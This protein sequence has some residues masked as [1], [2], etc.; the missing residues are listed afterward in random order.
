MSP[1]ITTGSPAALASPMLAMSPS[2]RLTSA[3]LPAPSQ[4]TTSNRDLR[5]ESAESTTGRSVRFIDWYERASAEAA[6]RPMTTTWQSRSPAGLS[7]TGFI[8]ASGATPAAAAC[9]AWARPISWPPAVTAELR[10]MF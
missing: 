4:T 3:G 6:G 1:T 10:A 8:A 5:S 7:S 9:I 2:R